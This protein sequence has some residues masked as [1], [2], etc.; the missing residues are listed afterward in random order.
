MIRRLPSAQ[1]TV[2]R[3][4]RLR[5]LIQAPEA[6]VDAAEDVSHWPDTVWIDW[7]QSAAVFVAWV[8]GSALGIVSEA[9]RSGRTE[10][11]LA[12]M[13]V[14]PRVRGKG[15]ADD[16]V[17]AFV[18]FVRDRGGER[19]SL[20]VAS[21]NAPASRLYGRHGFTP[22]GTTRQTPL[23]TIAEMTLDLGV[24][25]Y[26]D[27]M[28]DRNFVGAIPEVYDRCLGPLV[29]QP[30]AED[31]A[32]RLAA[33][34]VTRVLE[35]AAG[36]GIATAEVVR[37]VA[38][39]TRIVVTDL[40]QA[41]LDV[42]AGRVHGAN[43]EFQT[44][45]AQE[46]PFADGGFDAVYCQFGVMFLPDKDR[47]YAGMHRVLAP[48]GTLV[49]SVWDRIETSPIAV[50]VA[51]AVARR[52]PE[53]P[54]RFMSQIPHG[55]HDSATIRDAL[56]AAGFTDI[57]VETVTLPSVAPSAREAAVGFCQGTP[58][59]NEIIARDATGLAAI[60]DAVTDAVAERFGDGPVR[61]TMTALIVTAR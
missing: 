37:A 9:P 43:V 31:L 13:W 32:A 5:A 38:S 28:S 36:T 58:L 40:Q 51:E 60:T 33:L 48:G 6:F 20:W 1:W 53:N 27:K 17:S 22:T 4:I 18:G 35:L 57:A 29:F 3:D 2:L 39:G 26:S 59:R 42:A 15:L 14:D 49:F 34:P 16:L 44:V 56:G 19:I 50:A 54:P 11:G 8:D 24:N 52:F 25:V 41:M 23:G 45:D 7:L 30:Y 46:L 12:A 55:Y 21:R 10:Y 61:A 47:A